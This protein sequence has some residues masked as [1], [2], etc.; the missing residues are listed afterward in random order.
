[1]AATVLIVDDH[2]VFRRFARRLLEEDGFDVVGEAADGESAVAAVEALAP[3]IVL[4][5]LMLPDISGLEVADRLA[6]TRRERTL[7]LTSSRSRADYG[8]AIDAAAADGFV[9]KGDLTAASFRAV[10]RMA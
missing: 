7:V 10:L 4:L 3:D 9:A 5:D 6:S 2:A 1:M 8:L